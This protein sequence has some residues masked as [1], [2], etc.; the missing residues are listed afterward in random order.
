MS[1][2]LFISDLHLDPSRPGMVRLFLRFLE[3]HGRDCGPL[4]ILGDLFEVW[5]GDDNEVPEYRSVLDA[6][7]RCT[8]TGM[9]IFV[10]HGNRDFL[11]GEGFAGRTGCN[12]LPDPTVISPAGER[13]LLMHGDTL[14][15]GD[16]DYQEFRR[17]VRTPAWRS[18]FLS[19]T[20]EERRRIAGELRE[21]SQTA[22]GNKSAE[23]MDVDPHAV[24]QAFRS[25][26]VHHLIHGHTHRPGIHSLT[27]DNTPVRRFVLGDW[28]RQGSV[29][30]YESGNFELL[31]FA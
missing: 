3:D 11:L 28:Y 7:R 24:E 31:S 21:G 12:L 27:V 22:T 17:R 8:D 10:M 19:K 16:R 4:Y 18:Q 26:G 5:I 25:Y 15:T 2:T 6:L 30:R 1:A 20:I 13:L 23:I 29:L 14:C 9:P